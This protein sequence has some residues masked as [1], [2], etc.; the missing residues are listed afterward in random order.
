MK[1]TL[2]LIA[3]ALGGLLAPARA[4]PTNGVYRS[5][6]ENAWVVGVAHHMAQTGN[7]LAAVGGQLQ[8]AA[9]NPVSIA[10]VMLGLN[11]GLDEEGSLA[12]VVFPPKREGGDPMSVLY[13]QVT[14]YSQFIKPLRPRELGHD[15]SKVVLHNHDMLVAHKDDFAV[16]A[17]SEDEEALKKILSASEGIEKI[18][19][20]VSGWLARQDIAVLALPKS[21]EFGTKFAEQSL[22]QATQDLEAAGD[23]MKAAAAALGL[24]QQILT[25]I[26][27]EL[28]HGGIG[29]KINDA[30]DVLVSF[31]GAVEP[32]G[33][34]ARSLASIEW[35]KRL[36]LSQIPA[37]DYAMAAAMSYPQQWVADMM[38][39]N[40]K[41]MASMGS[42]GGTPLTEKQAQELT[43]L[44]LEGMEDIKA[45]SMVVR[46]IQTGEGFLDQTYGVMLCRDSERYLEKYP[47]LLEKMSKITAGS[48]SAM[49]PQTTAKPIKIGDRNGY[50]VTVDM[51]PMLKQMED[52]NP[53][54]SAFQ[55]K[56]FGE[57]G[58]LTAYLAA[59]D[60][61]TIV[62]TYGSKESLAEL[63]DVKQGLASDEGVKEINGLLPADPA[64]V[65]YLN[66][67]GIIEFVNAVLPMFQP[68]A[69]KLPEFPQAPPVGMALKFSKRDVE[70]RVAVKSELLETIGEYIQTTRN[71]Q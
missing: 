51:S 68:D 60:R 70:A 45:V 16:F 1:R 67:S 17:R 29:I 61:E 6:P 18:V 41:L 53:I 69:K 2:G 7:K 40:F 28:T 62:M 24:Y 38:H 8:L 15:L 33:E 22:A 65:V 11:E 64:G 19:E 35:P 54:A 50:E 12:V 34:F 5:I 71:P 46:P 37:G 30:G 57:D 27:S 55:K 21:I 66:G 13:V 58:M 39:Y 49:I 10:K 63:L 3:M 14:D 32:H 43:D 25:A 59:A 26:G 4:E 9:A 31:D 42:V 20:P 48:K 23:Q 44:S 36:G 47:E 52:A 56:I